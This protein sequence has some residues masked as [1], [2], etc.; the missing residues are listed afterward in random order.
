[1]IGIAN[2]ILTFLAA[3]LVYESGHTL[4]GKLAFALPLLALWSWAMMLRYNPALIKLRLERLKRQLHHQN[5]SP[6]EYTR[7]EEHIKTALSS[8]LPAMPKW[9]Q[10]INALGFLCGMGLLLWAGVTTLSH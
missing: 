5:L 9:I 7:I 3:I 4:V 2:V 1:M 10:I 8:G 6:E